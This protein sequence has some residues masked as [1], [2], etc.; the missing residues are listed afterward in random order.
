MYVE[1]PVSVYGPG[2]WMGDMPEVG[3]DITREEYEAVRRWIEECG[4]AEDY[5]EL[6]RIRNAVRDVCIE[7]EE[8]VDRDCLSISDLDL[9]ECDFVLQLPGLNLPEE[10]S[11]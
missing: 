11:E 8:G 1:F 9:D 5:P 3:L 6:N 2:G 10:F 4:D 7:T